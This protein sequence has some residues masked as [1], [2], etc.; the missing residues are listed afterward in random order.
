M[1]KTQFRYSQTS[2][3]KSVLAALGLTLIVTFLVWLF[4][5]LFGLRY[6]NT[7]TFVS[8]LIFFGFCSAAMI[9]RY[10]RKDIVL[11]VRP[12]G[13]FDARYSSEP[14]PWDA[15][16][17][18]RLGRVENDFQ[19][20]VYLWPRELKA[21]AE[22]QGFVIDLAP[23]DAGIEQVLDVVSGHKPVTVPNQ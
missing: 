11:A 14:V 21:D 12:D 1:S 5:Q 16:K 7:V 15:I 19:L 3:R 9:W 8:G 13:L 4:A 6:Y 17:D 23:L 18:I 2:F 20:S 22:E 10:L